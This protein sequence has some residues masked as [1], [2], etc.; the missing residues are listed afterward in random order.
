MFNKNL[1]CD[2][3]NQREQREVKHEDDSLAS[4]RDK[5]YKKKRIIENVEPKDLFLQNRDGESGY[6]YQLQKNHIQKCYKEHLINH[7]EEKIKI[8]QFGLN[9]NTN[10]S[11]PI[12]ST[13]PISDKKTK[14][15]QE[16][17]KRMM[18]DQLDY[19]IPGWRSYREIFIY[20]IIGKLISDGAVPIASQKNNN[21]VFSS[22]NINK[23]PKE[24]LIL[25]YIICEM[26]WKISSNKDLINH[27][28]SF[29]VS[30]HFKSLMTIPFF[31]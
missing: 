15:I 17:T 31:C 13:V 22:I 16:E 25:G 26:I 4:G 10:F 27:L 9:L 30:S 7:K 14:K 2:I 8:P 3:V 23:E 20:Y 28:W 24:D 1:L 19:K 11:I 21:W 12:Y 6:W 5:N 29:V 18:E